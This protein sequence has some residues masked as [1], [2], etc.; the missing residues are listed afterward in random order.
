[1]N[2][3]KIDGFDYCELYVSN[4]KQAAH[5]YHTA[6][7]FYPIAYCG[8]ETGSRDRVSYVLKQNQI[9]F[10]LTSPLNNKSEISK[11]IYNHGDGVKDISFTVNDAETA[12]KVSIERGAE[13]VREPHLLSDDRGETVMATIKAFGDTNHT[14]VQRNNYNGVFLPGYVVFENNITAD[15]T[16]LIHIDHIVGNQPNG[17]MQSVCNFYEKVFGWHRFWTVDDKDIS[18]EFSALRS[19]VMANDNE[20]IKMP[21]NEPAD[22]LKKSQIQ[23][24]ID[25]YNSPGI[26]HIAMSTKDIINTV[27]KLKEKGV[28]FLETPKSYYDKLI[29]RIGDIDED[30]D[31]IKD[32]G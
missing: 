31:Q 17:E 5:F 28:Q 11:H 2:N 26:Q 14:F 4:A 9:K 6:L 13:S 27:F 19:I 29:E 22:G 7:G 18:T 10:I 12:W 24:F 25:Y 30:L 20:K 21:I 32:L 15:P 16:G 8:L 1:M 3:Y 23:E